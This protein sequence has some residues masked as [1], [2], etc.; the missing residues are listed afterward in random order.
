MKDKEI[1]LNGG[2]STENVVQIGNTVHRTKCS[3]FNF[4]HSLLRYLEQHNFPYSPRFLGTDN[5]DREILSFI[6]GDV[7]GDVPLTYTQKINA[8][9]ILREFHDL[10]ANSFL[11]QE[12][13]TV[14]HND[15]APWNIIVNDSRVVGVIDFDEVAPG[16]RIDDVAYFIWT[17]LE[18]GTSQLP[19]TKQIENIVGLVKAYHLD[20]KEKLI[21]AFLNQQNRILKFRN[22]IV[23]KEQDSAK[24][25][26]SR[27][28]VINIRKSM[29]WVK[30]NKDKI[31]DA[32]KAI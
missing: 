3:N 13:E 2:R 17:F 24:R 32:L 25:E 6:K 22:Q 15:F 1:I 29:D 9:K 14:C 21:P 27:N 8:I 30:V 10:L 23:L 20:D 4:V 26:F 7:P 16:K 11:C 19:N 18:L 31:E 5:K 12:H 28:A